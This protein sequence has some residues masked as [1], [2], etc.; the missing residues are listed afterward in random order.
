MDFIDKGEIMKQSKILSILAN[1][2]QLR[3]GATGVVWE[4]DTLAQALE[5]L[6]NQGFAYGDG[7]DRFRLDIF[8]GCV[9]VVWYHHDAP[10]FHNGRWQH[11]VE[12]AERFYI[13]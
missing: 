8:R 3:S 4:Y 7:S 1:G 13:S 5:I 10:W 11:E 2:T 9:C 12:F 6:F